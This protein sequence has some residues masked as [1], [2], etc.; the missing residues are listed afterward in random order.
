M[1]LISLCKD[2]IQWCLYRKTEPFG[3]EKHNYP[4]YED[5]ADS[6]P[7][8]FMNGTLCNI[9]KFIFNSILAINVAMNF[10]GLFFTDLLTQTNGI[11]Q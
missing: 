5:C 2:Q 8:I 7:K 9:I 10:T 11:F 6:F 4:F 3:R 1:L